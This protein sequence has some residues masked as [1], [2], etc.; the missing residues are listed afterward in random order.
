M[1]TN[2]H[3]KM[4]MPF[5][6]YSLISIR[7]M[8]EIFTGSGLHMHTVELMLIQGSNINRPYLINVKQHNFFLFN[9]LFKELFNKA[10]YALYTTI[11]TPSTKYYKCCSSSTRYPTAL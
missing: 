7:A 2:A 1:H 11:F 10:L 6:P 9:H 8:C 5:K 4:Q 3:R